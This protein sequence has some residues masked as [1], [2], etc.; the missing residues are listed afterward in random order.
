MVVHKIIPNTFC[1]QLHWGI[2]DRKAASILNLKY[3]SRGL[4]LSLKSLR[5]MIEDLSLCSYVSVLRFW[6]ESILI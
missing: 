5:S 1:N 4:P 3:T 6:R 2:N